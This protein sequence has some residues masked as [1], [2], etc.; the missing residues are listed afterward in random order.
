MKIFAALLLIIAIN[1]SSAADYNRSEWRHWI[2]AD[3]DCQ[4]TRAEILIV[5]SK[6]PVKFKDA[7]GCKVKSGL[8]IDPYTGRKFTDP[9]DIHIDHIVPLAHA[10][11][12]GAQHWTSEQ[13]K[14]FANDPENLIAVYRGA[15]QSKSAKA[16]HQWLP[17]NNQHR[18]IYAKRWLAVKIKYRLRTKTQERHSL[19][20]NYHC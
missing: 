19:Q 12:H 17:V 16:P 11:R 7:K 20:Q 15:N 9:S 14:Q 6:I 8:W 5:S 2:D 13:R 18:C 3:R 4:N 10:H 1:A